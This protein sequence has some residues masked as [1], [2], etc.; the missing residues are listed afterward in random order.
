MTQA[1]R[2]AAQLGP[3]WT[4]IGF[5]PYYVALVPPAV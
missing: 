4:M 1:R 3:E 2:K 5:R